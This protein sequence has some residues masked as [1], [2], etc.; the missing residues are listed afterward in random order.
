MPLSKGG[1]EP[2]RVKLPLSEGRIGQ[3]CAKL[4]LPRSGIAP[5]WA[6]LTL[7]KNWAKF[8]NVDTIQGWAWAR[9]VDLGSKLA[10][11]TVFY[12]VKLACKW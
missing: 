6:M 5:N 1:I 11:K 8:G 7:S 12:L 10:K 9:T 2:H 4:T 3:N